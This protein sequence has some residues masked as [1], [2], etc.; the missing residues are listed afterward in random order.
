M[1]AWD[2][3]RLWRRLGVVLTV[4]WIGFVVL[5]SFQP[6]YH[7]NLDLSIITER[8]DGTEG[9][10]RCTPTPD[11]KYC[12]EPSPGYWTTHEIGPGGWWIAV[13]ATMIWAVCL[14]IPWISAARNR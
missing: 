14:G 5:R 11:G 6:V 7:G 1:D 8:A 13:G 4:L 9:F 10:N 2:N 3:R 12:V